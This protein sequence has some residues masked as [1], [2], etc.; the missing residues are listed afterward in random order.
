MTCGGGKNRKKCIIMMIIFL[1][2]LL[3]IYYMII[4]Y[5]IFKLYFYL[6]HNVRFLYF[7]EIYK[8]FFWGISFICISI[9]WL[10]LPMICLLALPR[11]FSKLQLGFCSSFL[12]DIS[13]SCFSSPLAYSATL[14]PI[15]RVLL[16]DAGVQ[17][18]QA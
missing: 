10:A 17:C 12:N 13:L 14:L 11:F 3:F 6:F 9:S 8:R 2:V 5:S 18:S 1:F 4:F 16:P 7:P 15:T